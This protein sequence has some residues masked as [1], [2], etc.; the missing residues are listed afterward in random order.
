MFG[1]L[2]Q[3]KVIETV[4]L[5]MVSFYSKSKLKSISDILGTSGDVICAEY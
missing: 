1:E 5:R 4:E 2:G 3:H